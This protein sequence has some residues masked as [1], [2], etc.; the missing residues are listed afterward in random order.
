MFPTFSAMT[1]A[2][3]AT[4]TIWLK[5]SYLMNLRWRRETQLTSTSTAKL[6]KHSNQIKIFQRSKIDKEPS[7]ILSNVFAKWFYLSSS[8]SQ[9]ISSMLCCNFPPM[10]LSCSSWDRNSCDG[11]RSGDASHFLCQIHVKSSVTFGFSRERTKKKKEN[12]FIQSVLI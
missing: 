9:N 7:I 11:S 8:S 10:F 6:S 5:S 3:V 4:R 2:G 1:E 12:C